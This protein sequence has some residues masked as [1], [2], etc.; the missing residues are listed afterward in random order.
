MPRAKNTFEKVCHEFVRPTGPRVEE[1]L[2][3]ALFTLLQAAQRV[4]AKAPKDSNM[5]SCEVD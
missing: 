1:L 3:K 4:A 2:K 5:S